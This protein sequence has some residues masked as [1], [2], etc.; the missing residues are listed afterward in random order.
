MPLLH[1]PGCNCNCDCL[2]TEEEDYNQSLTANTL[3]EIAYNIRVND[4]IDLTKLL[5][6]D[7]FRDVDNVFKVHIK[8]VTGTTT[9][10]TLTYQSIR[11]NTG[12]I[13][14]YDP[15][16]YDSVA[17]GDHEAR[18]DEGSY[19]LSSDWAFGNYVPYKTRY[20][21][22]YTRISDGTN[23]WESHQSYKQLKV[24]EQ[25]YSIKS[26]TA[27]TYEKQEGRAYSTTSSYGSDIT[28]TQCVT[29]CRKEMKIEFE[30]KR[31]VFVNNQTTQLLTAVRH[32]IDNG[33]DGVLRTK[34]FLQQLNP[35]DESTVLAQGEALADV[36]S[37][38]E[39][40]KNRS[41][42]LSL[43]ESGEK[44]IA[45]LATNWSVLYC[46]EDSDSYDPDEYYNFQQAEVKYL[47]SA[48]ETG[49]GHFQLETRYVVGAPGTS[50]TVKVFR[51]GGNST[52]VDVVVAV[53]NSDV[54]LNFSAGDIY[55]EF[56]ISHSSHD[57]STFTSGMTP[58][59]DS[60]RPYGTE[61]S[62]SLITGGWQEAME[63]TFRKDTY[64]FGYIANGADWTPIKKVGGVES[65][66]TKVPYQRTGWDNIPVRVFVESNVDTTLLSFV[67]TGVRHDGKCG[68]DDDNLP[69]PPKSPCDVVPEYHNQQWDMEFD[70]GLSAA[71]MPSIY[72]KANL[73]CTT[74]HTYYND[75]L[76][77]TEQ[78]PVTLQDDPL[79]DDRSWCN[80][81]PVH[82][83]QTSNCQK[84]HLFN[85]YGQ[86][87]SYK[88][89]MNVEKVDLEAEA[90]LVRCYD[91][92]F[93]N[94]QEQSVTIE[95][96]CG[97][98][99]DTTDLSN[100]PRGCVAYNSIDYCF[101]H[102][103]NDSSYTYTD[104]SIIA[105]GYPVGD[106][107]DQVPWLTISAAFSCHEFVE[108]VSAQH[109]TY[110]GVNLI[111]ASVTAW[112]VESEETIQ[113]PFYDMNADFDFYRD[114]NNGA[115]YV[116]ERFE[117]VNKTPFGKN[118]GT[119]SFTGDSSVIWE[120]RDTA[121]L[122][123][124]QGFVME[125]TT[126]DVT[127]QQIADELDYLPLSGTDFWF[128][129]TNTSDSSND[130]FYRVTY[131]NTLDGPYTTADDGSGNVFRSIADDMGVQ[132]RLK[133]Q[134]YKS[135]YAGESGDEP[136]NVDGISIPVPVSHQ[137]SE[138]GGIS[139]FEATYRVND[140]KYYKDLQFDVGDDNPNGLPSKIVGFFPEGTPVDD[141]SGNPIFFEDGQGGVGWPDS[142]YFSD[143]T[144]NYG[145]WASSLNLPPGY[146]DDTEI[147][148]E[149][150]VLVYVTRRSGLTSP[151]YNRE[152]CEGDANGANEICCN[153][154]DPGTET[155][156]SEY[157]SYDG[158]AEWNGE[159]ENNLA[160]Y[161]SSSVT[162]INTYDITNVI[163]EVAEYAFIIKWE[164]C[165]T[166]MD[167]PT[168]DFD[169]YSDYIDGPDNIY[170]FI[171]A[172][173]EP[174]GDSTYKPYFDQPGASPSAEDPW[175]LYYDV[176]V[177]S[178][179]VNK[180]D[181]TFTAK[182]YTTQWQK[183]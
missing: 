124:G 88:M 123:V 50:T 35:S 154:E 72:Y 133:I 49:D 41:F 106:L 156:V 144:P 122:Y 17:A 4:S 160:G 159:F 63:I 183:F 53:G 119:G 69:C 55:K 116:G 2:V 140:Q 46:D 148:P 145:D 85:R 153:G 90:R 73:G 99:Q 89:L 7:Y 178:H 118:V 51:T 43:D 107:P 166:G 150:F 95:L 32:D 29:G 38:G 125:V 25:R 181:F 129:Y 126:S 28:A 94:S 138:L 172:G 165:W 52:A 104:G 164:E 80:T 66:R 44:G 86:I 76:H 167:Q 11:D 87:G 33:A 163:R 68:Y 158:M 9:Y 132:P 12:Y 60:V 3:H 141:G 130:G 14:G 179:V 121:F 16:D 57:G 143:C 27:G 136:W 10:E 110:N 105:Y 75:H 131:P 40:A 67:I 20:Y 1:S 84:W 169:A 15:Y 13:D 48:S 137:Y 182:A 176:R 139:R 161:R 146:H 71:Y 19:F 174:G 23:N 56:T 151:I 64:E 109:S 149:G 162:E 93:W 168:V 180:S 24:G 155:I 21:K 98:F 78:Y 147:V 79:F 97:T 36:W 77:A 103:C 65:W 39:K 82:Y 152:T 128:E 102:N 37:T 108:C 30:K 5:P 117:F 62:D 173:L 83:W 142:V 61:E 42:N 81:S 171:D 113:S 120:M 114:G 127:A 115:N 18:F 101:E 8:D 177:R 26:V 112:Q 92:A 134:Y 70:I 45:R 34:F 157:W 47:P 170:P 22:R 175:Y 91:D 6:N 74:Q 31:Y 54:T 100:M 58:T 96:P 111:N 59:N 135:F